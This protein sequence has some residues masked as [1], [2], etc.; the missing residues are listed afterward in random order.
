[1]KKH[2][3]IGILIAGVCLYFAFRGI[4]FR[5]LGTTLSHGRPG[6]ILLALVIYLIGYVLRSIRWSVLIRPIQAIP[7]VDLAAVM[8]LGFFAN[9]ILPLR[10]GELI[11]AHLCGTKFKISRTASL[12]SIL[13]ERICD[14]IGFLSTFIVASL[15]YPF[16]H[17]M[18]KG[19]WML[20][21]SCV[22][23]IAALIFVRFQEPMFHRILDASPL[24]DRW[25][26]KIK[27]LA[28]QFIHST[29]GLTQPRYV[30]EA[31]TLSL[32]IWTIEGT[33]LYLMAI[34]F[35]LNLKYLQA[36]F[37]LFALGISV[38]LPQAPGYVGTFELFGITALA[39]LGIPKSEGLPVILAVHGT[40]FFYIAV[41]GCL[42][43]WKEGLRFSSL[44][45]TSES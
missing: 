5:E 23:V 29:A 26:M 27:H 11:R 44:T 24:P 35:G 45:S 43:L 37:L 18:Q 19:A 12:G 20:G 41:L 9:N 7:A 4:S 40:Q 32:V 2:L 42:A 39:L 14:S 31:L 22:I 13:L 6:P 1:M 17:Y 28:T 8:I 3:W 33:Y 21:G 30:I 38:T 34:A 36:F 10:M 25:K 15:F 16:P